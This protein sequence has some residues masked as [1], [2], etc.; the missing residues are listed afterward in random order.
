MGLVLQDYLIDKW[1]WNYYRIVELD[2]D[3]SFGI[4]EEWGEV[5]ADEAR[6]WYNEE[7]LPG[8]F[9]D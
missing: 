8:G 3:L 7:G 4:L 1:R 6:C 5:K 9:G 2:Y